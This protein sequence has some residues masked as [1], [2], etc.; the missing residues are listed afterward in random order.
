MY[1]SLPVE[2]VSRKHYTRGNNNKWRW[3]VEGIKANAKCLF[4]VIGRALMPS[5]AA[6]DPCGRETV[7]RLVRVAHRGTLGYLSRPGGQGEKQSLKGELHLPD[8]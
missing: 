7:V 3:S 2:K 8:G 6:G 5:A 1:A 4:H